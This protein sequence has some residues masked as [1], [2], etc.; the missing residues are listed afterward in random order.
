MALSVYSELYVARL[1][2]YARIIDAI[3]DTCDGSTEGIDGSARAAAMT[4]LGELGK[5]GQGVQLAGWLDAMLTA[6]E[7]SRREV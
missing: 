3:A 6:H 5:P 2:T 4:I 1:R 7:N